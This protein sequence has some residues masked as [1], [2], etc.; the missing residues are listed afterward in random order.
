MQNKAISAAKSRLMGA[1]ERE[2]ARLHTEKE[3]FEDDKRRAERRLD[4]A[5]NDIME[6]ETEYL[7]MFGRRLQDSHTAGDYE[8]SLIVTDANENGLT[9]KWDKPIRTK[10][11]YPAL[12][13]ETKEEH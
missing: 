7:A 6:L 11:Q 10:K 3:R 8:N 4:A 1:F 5:N 12:G 2:H 9:A 13:Y